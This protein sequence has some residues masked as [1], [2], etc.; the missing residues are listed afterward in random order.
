V[1]TSVTGVTRT[2]GAVYR[3]T[4]TWGT[5]MSSCVIDVSLLRWV[6]AM[7]GEPEPA[8]VSPRRA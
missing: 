1:I 5:V 4:W 3:A 2:C 8:E 7:A 6:W